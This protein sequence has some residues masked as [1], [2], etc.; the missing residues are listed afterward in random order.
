MTGAPRNASS[1]VY[2]FISGWDKKRFVGLIKEMDEAV[3]R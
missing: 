3:Q 1:E 2:D